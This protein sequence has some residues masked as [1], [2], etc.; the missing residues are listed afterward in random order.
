[1]GKERGSNRWKA[2]KDW[3]IV[4]RDVEKKMEV[5]L[6]LWECTV[7][8]GLVAMAEWFVAVGKFVA[9]VVALAETMFDEI[10]VVV[11]KAIEHHFD[12]ALAP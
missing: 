10:A 11:G 2:R 8:I 1:M 4:Q 5:I 9:I 3:N 6:C 7:D 12:R